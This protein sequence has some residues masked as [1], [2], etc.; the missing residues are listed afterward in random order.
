[1]H[2]HTMVTGPVKYYIYKYNNMKRV[3]HIKPSSTT[4]AA[5]T[6]SPHNTTGCSASLTVQ[7]AKEAAHHRQTFQ[8]H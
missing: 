4:G 8:Q 3:M 5:P 7:I 6:H 1:M 2:M